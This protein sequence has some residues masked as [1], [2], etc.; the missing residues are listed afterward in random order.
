[1]NGW[2]KL[3]T[4]FKRFNSRK[5]N[6]IKA[7][8]Y[9]HSRIQSWNYNSSDVCI[10]VLV[11]SKEIRWG[12]SASRTFAT[13]ISFLSS[14][15][16]CSRCDTRETK[17]ITSS[18]TAYTPSANSLYYIY[19]IYIVG[20]L[21]RPN[22]CGVFEE[23]LYW[24]VCVLLVAWETDAGIAGEKHRCREK[25]AWRPIRRVTRVI[26]LPCTRSRMYFSRH[27]QDSMSSSISLSLTAEANSVQHW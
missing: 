27:A 25:C 12:N 17:L 2:N 24:E 13:T 23:I 19:T 9:E 20:W 7:Q 8:G 15:L 3:I 22:T 26:S 6:F 1:M 4:V 11:R 21:L 16:T 18:S 14:S 10:N 5:L